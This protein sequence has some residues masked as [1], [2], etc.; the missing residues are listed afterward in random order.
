MTDHHEDWQERLKKGPFTEEPFTEEQK[1]RV[2]QT[3]QN[4]TSHTQ[5]K[6]RFQG[7][8]RIL[9][10]CSISGAVLACAWWLVPGSLDT[11]N[12][13]ITAE[14]AAET[15]EAESMDA[16]SNTAASQKTSSTDADV[17]A[18]Y[19]Q[20]TEESAANDSK[21]YSES[22]TEDISNEMSVIPQS[23]A[24]SESLA[25]SYSS[26]EDLIADSVLAAEVEVTGTPSS[27]ANL[28][29]KVEDVLYSK[30]SD[31]TPDEIT[32][33]YNAVQDQ[34]NTQVEDTYHPPLSTGDRAILFLKKDEDSDLYYIAGGYQGSYIIQGGKVSSIGENIGTEELQQI[35]QEN[36][37][38]RFITDM[39][40][41]E[42]KNLVAATVKKLD[43]H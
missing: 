43:N 28:K 31:I 35:E 21:E 3:V 32:L 5:Q 4:L 34:E 9:L 27:T 13:A 29:L 10:A 22:E 1:Q 14:Q 26:I 2:I 7:V 6:P 16:G 40:T 23:S 25:Y 18:R 37:T 39:D 15:S 41:L 33:S 20:A 24:S 8:K 19:S 42:F 12:I 30:P 38:P 11:E 17:T 36:K